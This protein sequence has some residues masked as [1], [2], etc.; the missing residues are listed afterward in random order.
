LRADF[1]DAPAI[2]RRIGFG[3]NPGTPTPIEIV[4]VVKD[5]TY[6]D[7]R[8]QAQHQVFFPYFE[9]SQ[10]NAFTIYA[11]TAIP[12]GATF[13]T[14]RRVVQG[15]DPHLPIHTTRT[16]ERQVA[17]SL[18]RERL[19]A[20]MTGAFGALATALAMVGLYGVMSYS[21]ARRTREI[22]VRVAMGATAS[23][24]RW[25]VAREMLPIVAAGVLAA[26]PLAWWLGRYVA[27]QL[28]GVEP[29]DPVAVMSAAGLL[30]LVAVAAALL[31]SARAARL[32]PTVALREG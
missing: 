23:N 7:V 24:I 1:G 5:S 11:R 21:V 20:A 16:L 2:G 14:I 30:G 25:L 10:P 4:G 31:P 3:G 19:V 13:T 22:G 8:D 28:Y 26:L 12:P 27:A 18:R 32:D 6:T 15:L 17:Q 9:M 29:F